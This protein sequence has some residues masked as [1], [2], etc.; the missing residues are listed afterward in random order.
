[1]NG[2]NLNLERKMDKT[3]IA[4]LRMVSDAVSL[5]QHYGTCVSCFN[6]DGNR[7][8]TKPYL[9]FRDATDF[10]QAVEDDVG[11]NKDELKISKTDFLSKVTVDDK[12]KSIVENPNTEF[13][14]IP[15]RDSHIM[16]DSDKDIHHFYK[17]Q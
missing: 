12:H 7:K 10:A 6:S 8:R 9:P 15:D 4:Y 11:N 3:S 2:V 17:H 16:Y 13:L 14:Y 5:K 1:M